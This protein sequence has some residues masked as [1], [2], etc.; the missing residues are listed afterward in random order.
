MTTPAIQLQYVSPQ[1]N[2]FAPLTQP[3]SLRAIVDKIKTLILSRWTLVIAVGLITAFAVGIAPAL[4]VTAIAALAASLLPALSNTKKLSIFTA[5][6]LGL[7]YDPFEFAGDYDPFINSVKQK[8]EALLIGRATQDQTP[9]Q[10]ATDLRYGPTLEELL[11][12]KLQTQ[13]L[14]QCKFNGLNH[15][16]FQKL[17]TQLMKEHSQDR[18]FYFLKNCPPSLLGIDKALRDAAK[19]ANTPFDMP[20]INSSAIIEGNTRTAQKRH[21]SHALFTLAN[22]NILKASDERDKAKT[23]IDEELAR[24]LEN[25]RYPYIVGKAS[26]PRARPAPVD[27]EGEGPEVPAELANGPEALVRTDIDPKLIKAFKSP[28]GRMLFY[29]LYQIMNIHLASDIMGEV[30]EAK[31]RFASGMGD[32][33]KRAEV[34]AKKFAAENADIVMAQEC[35]RHLPQEMAKL[36]YFST[37]KKLVKDPSDPSNTKWV[38][39]SGDGSVIFFNAKTFKGA[40]IHPYDETLDPKHKNTIATAYF[41]GAE[42]PIVVASCHVSDSNNKSFARVIKHVTQSIYQKGT[43]AAAVIGLDANPQSTEDEDD[44]RSFL[45]D[46]NLH[47]VKVGPT[48]IKMRLITLLHKKIH[49]LIRREKNMVVATGDGCKLENPTVAFQHPPLDLNIMMPNKNMLS[50]QAP[51]GVKM[52]IKV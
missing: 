40:H 4:L 12:S 11:P 24:E 47:T 2:T 17:L 52:T 16:L 15:K 34:F 42:R 26:A 1:S 39:N 45:Q 21:L 44:I 43:H 31:R 29:Y 35:D 7:F 32:P 19:T 30:N 36:G 41:L 6:M 33:Q 14:E 38:L 37:E 51:V 25:P 5:N 18:L 3:N 50:D 8:L 49:D 46:E 10:I 48:S 20:I 28:E 27:E 22:L 9:E 23:T 13:L